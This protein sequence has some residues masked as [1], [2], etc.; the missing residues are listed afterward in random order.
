[1]AKRVPAY[2]SY[3]DKQNFN[4]KGVKK[5]N[6]FRKIPTIDKTDYLRNYPLEE[7]C[8]DGKFKQKRWVIS[9][10]SGSTG[11]PFYFPRENV[12]DLQYAG[13]A[14]LYLITNFDIQKKS[15]LY[16][17]AFPMGI[18]IGGLFTY[19][20]I[21]IIA[22]RGNY[23]LSIITTSVD[24]KEIINSVKKFGEKYDQIII[25]CYGPFL[26]DA[27]DEGLAQG[28]DWK[29]Y[30]LKFIF[31]AEGFCEEF[32]DYIAEKTGLK[33]IYRDTLNHYG[34][35]D[36]GTLAY[37]TP[38]AILIRRLAVKQSRFLYKQIFPNTK[39][40]PTLCQYDPELFF[41]E[42]VR[43]QLLCSAF[44]G[45]PLVR[46]D[47]KDNGG[48]IGFED[49]MSKIKK[50]GIDIRTEAK[51][52]GI[53]DTI[54]RLP[55]V[56]VYER[57]DFSVSLY[58]FQIYPETIRRVLLESKFHEDITGKFTMMV[59]GDQNA[60]QLF[61]VNIELKLHRIGS[62]KLEKIIEH[63]I[64]KHLIAENSEYRK[65]YSENPVGIKPHIVFWDYEHPEYFSNKGKQKWIKK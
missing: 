9:A 28:I 61:E 15:T 36:Q 58:G 34:T 51:K 38:L 49:M 18:W 45:L 8:W 10:T 56:Y 13:T 40:L 24:K 57:S 21:K 53:E 59:K 33:N 64:T 19:E 54:W 22:E 41:F 44:S 55:F 23:P 2:K 47:L 17:D 65:T 1:M 16:I 25:G 7:L 27:I 30:N 31:S 52:A 26:K 62:K 6:D 43:G 12:Q 32:R 48:V 39:K 46:Y 42:E 3:L 37:E 4:S 50:S 20:A 11:E 14:E 35:V 63:E 29:K 5:F 60:N